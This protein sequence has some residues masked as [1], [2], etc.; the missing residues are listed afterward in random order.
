M[1][2]TERLVLRP[3]EPRDA[4]D[5][6]RLINDWEVTRT[7]AVVPFPYPRELADDEADDRLVVDERSDKGVDLWLDVCERFCGVE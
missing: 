3:L 6:H 1:I 5:L 7:L 4:E 2:R